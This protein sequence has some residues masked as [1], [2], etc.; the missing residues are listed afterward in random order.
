MKKNILII[1]MSLLILSCSESKI[2]FNSTF[3]N[4]ETIV[5]I[6][7]LNKGV[8]E[9]ELTSCYNF[10]QDNFPEIKIL[11]GPKLK[12]PS[13][14]Y[15]GKRYRADSILKYLDRIKPDSVTKVIGIT[16]SD[17]SSTRTLIKDGKKVTYQD[18]GIL[19]L[20]RKPGTVSVVSNFRMKGNTETFSKTV[21]HEFM[22]TL[23]VPH[24]NHEKCIMQDGKGSAKNIRE[25]NHV[26]KECI[27]KAMK[28]F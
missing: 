11:K 12:L 23:G 9:Q 28:G 18:Y 2:N 10:L 4:S 14:C 26:S 15:N 20:G 13:N 7:E 3:K 6:M 22:H 24:C 19:G 27:A 8:S 16:S 17:I 21:L 1:L 25:A 5:L